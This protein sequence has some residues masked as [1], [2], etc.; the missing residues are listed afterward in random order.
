MN[1]ISELPQAEQDAWH[2]VM[3]DHAYD[4]NEWE[5]A[6]NDLI[7]RL[8]SQNKKAKESAIRAYIAC[9]AEAVSSSGPLPLL[10][11]AVDDFFSRYGMEESLPN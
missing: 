5:R 3:L 11:T 10:T 8:Q 7:Q 6:R 2:Q 9:C 4:V 1:L